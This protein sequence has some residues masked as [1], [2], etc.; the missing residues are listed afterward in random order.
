MSTKISLLAEATAPTENVLLPMLVSGVTRKTFLSNVLSLVT[1]GTAI[2]ENVTG[3]TNISVVSAGVSSTKQLTISFDLPGLIV[4]YSGPDSSVPASWLF[5]NGQAVLR[6]GISG[7]PSL[8]AVIGTTYGSGD[9]TTTFNVPDL[10]GRI[11][12]GKATGS[13]S[14]SP[15]NGAS[16]SSGNFYTLASA[17]G[18]ETHLLTSGQT[19]VKDHTHTA[20]GTMTVYG[21]STDTQ[22]WDD[23]DTSPPENYSDN[24]FLGE[25]APGTQKTVSS[26]GTS[27]ALSPANASLSHTNIPPVI[28]L[29]YLIKT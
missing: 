10:R 3:G 6:S 23:P 18:E 8:F 22:N 20:I 4:P 5:C 19:P 14:S 16:F 7:Y 24:G 12:F 27:S 1:G 17:G 15:L 13:G 21:S 28:V 26:T 9:G 25:V 29:N 11:P 2:A